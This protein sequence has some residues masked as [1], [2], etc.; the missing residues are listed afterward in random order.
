VR[1]DVGIHI[2]RPEFV[3][4]DDNCWIDRGAII[5]AG[6]DDSLRERITRP[7]TD[8]PGDPG[9]VFIGKNVHLGP[10]TIVSGISGG[11]YVSDDCTFSAG[12]KIYAF[13]H[14]FRSEK[15]P[16][17]Q[18]V[19]FGSMGDHSRQTIIEG[20]IFFGT[21][22]GFA[23]NAVVLP[24]VSIGSNSFVAINSVVRSGTFGSNSLIEG[25]P[26]KKVRNRFVVPG[27]KT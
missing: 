4:I 24:G 1:L 2:Y 16:G 23:L 22:T 10:G 8:Y 9:C 26:A 12:C 11:V 7:N 5:L 13:T 18:S 20:A 27:G 25:N 6:P 15:S 14:H 3:S 19:H 21:N 17:M